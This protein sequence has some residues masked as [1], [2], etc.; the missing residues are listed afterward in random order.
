MDVKQ[1][2]VDVEE[3]IPNDGSKDPSKSQSSLTDDLNSQNKPDDS[4][5]HQTLTGMFTKENILM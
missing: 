5:M 2:S 3:K 4:T 1:S